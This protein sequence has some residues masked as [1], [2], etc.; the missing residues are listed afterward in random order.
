MAN[1]REVLGDQATLDALVS[2]T[3]TS[4]VDDEIDELCNYAFSDKTNLQSVALPNLTRVGTGAFMSAG[5]IHIT[6][7][8]LPQLTS[9]SSL[10][11][12]GCNYLVD[13][14]FP[15]VTSVSNSFSV[16]VLEKLEFLSSSKVTF[17][18][19]YPSTI[20]AL[21]LH[22]TTVASTSTTNPVGYN[23]SD[24]CG[25]VYVPTDMVASY[26][27]DS[28]WG[29]FNIAPISS[30]PLTSFGTIS[31]TWEEIQAAQEDGTYL[32]KYSIG[33]TKDIT[34]N[35]EPYLAEIVGFDLDEAENSNASANITWMLRYL[36][37]KRMM[38]DNYTSAG[39]WES[40]DLRSHL[41]NDVLPTINIKNYIVPV[42]KTFKDYSTSSTR[43][44]TDSLWIPSHREVFNDSTYETSGCVY[45]QRFTDNA[46]R[47]KYYQGSTSWWWLRSA[48]SNS[49]R[50]ID[51]Q[52]QGNSSSPN[53]NYSVALG[54]C[55]GSTTAI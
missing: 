30:Y 17:A 11:F 16:G 5:L 44:V 24:G 1:T 40:S 9:L 53:T 20:K 7:E 4:F 47:K 48:L 46:S 13:A 10:C 26:K 31:D 23:T 8:S 27:A 43:S 18:S 55:T 54:F 45:A 35:G 6:A 38:N 3:L 25:A 36:T 29:N 28:K 32:S 51:N 41:I 37:E 52:G 14:V 12:S 50:I 33:D 21:V 2:N 19:G 22:C 49:F 39:G 15:K 42:V 34:I